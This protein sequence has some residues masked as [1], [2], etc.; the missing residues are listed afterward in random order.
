MEDQLAW[1]TE[2]SPAAILDGRPLS[3]RPPLPL[4]RGVRARIR[5]AW[6]AR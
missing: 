1:M 6:S 5:R 4:A 3:D 2:A